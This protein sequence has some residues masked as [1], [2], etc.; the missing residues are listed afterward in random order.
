MEWVLLIVLGLVLF[1][2]FGLHSKLDALSL[3]ERT[4]AE[5]FETMREDVKNVNEKLRVI[6]KRIL[7]LREYR[8][9]Q[10]YKTAMQSHIE[11]SETIPD[12]V[13]RM[14]KLDWTDA[15]GWDDDE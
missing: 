8:E 12:S 13:K 11:K 3:I 4:R 2:L 6:N 5:E 1:V 9:I 14:A 10:M 7:T 15:V